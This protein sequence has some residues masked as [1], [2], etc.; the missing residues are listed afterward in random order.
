[1]VFMGCGFI[2]GGQRLGFVFRI[3]VCKIRASECYVASLPLVLKDKKG[4]FHKVKVCYKT[5]SWRRKAQL[6]F[7]TPVV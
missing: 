1:M 6:A 7:D 5:A 4:C 3:A 2:S